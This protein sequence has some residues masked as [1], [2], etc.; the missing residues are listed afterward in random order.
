MAEENTV[1]DQGDAPKSKSRRR[2]L[3]TAGIVGGGLVVGIPLM[4]VGPLF[5][6]LGNHFVV[7][8]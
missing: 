6:S 1:Q 8:V 5:R 7:R 4:R 2:F 3:I